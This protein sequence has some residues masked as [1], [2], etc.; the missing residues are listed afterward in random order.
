MVGVSVQ[1]PSPLEGET[2]FHRFP[3]VQEDEAV[4]HGGNLLANA[5]L[6]SCFPVPVSF[7]ILLSVLSGI[8]SQILVPK[9]VSGGIQAKLMHHEPRIMIQA[10]MA[11]N[12]NRP[13]AKP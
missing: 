3:D 11:H 1:T 2:Y 6:M 5:P 13:Y 7:P 9:F 12:K 8:I 4:V 10:H